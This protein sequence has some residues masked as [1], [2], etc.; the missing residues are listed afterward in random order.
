MKDYLEA[1]SEPDC[2]RW[3]AHMSDHYIETHTRLYNRE[4]ALEACESH[5]PGAS[6]RLT[7]ST[8]E[9]S[10]DRDEAVVDYEWTN[11]DDAGSDSYELALID[12]TWFIDGI[13]D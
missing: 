13:P 7:Y 3:I 10:I 1:A 6:E 11:G 9:E 2:E 8:F 12:G 4:N 5:P